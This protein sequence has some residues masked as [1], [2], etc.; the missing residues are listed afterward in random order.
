[1]VNGDGSYKRIVLVGKSATPA[2]CNDTYFKAHGLEYYNNPKAWM[3]SKIFMGLLKEFDQS[4]SG[5]AI[6]LLE[7]FSGHAKDLDVHI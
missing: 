2:K 4:L 5:P 6:L 7:N 1:M 3:N